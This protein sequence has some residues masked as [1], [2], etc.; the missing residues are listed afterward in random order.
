[1]VWGGLTSEPS[2]TAPRQTPGPGGYTLVG[3]LDTKLTAAAPLT[4][5]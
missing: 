2:C 1:V 3:R 5:A 4:L